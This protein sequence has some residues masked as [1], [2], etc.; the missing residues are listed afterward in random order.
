M[1]IDYTVMIDAVGPGVTAIIT[2][3]L[4]VAVILMA[5][6]LVWSG[7]RYV[8]ALVRGGGDGFRDEVE[9][10]DAMDA[11]ERRKNRGTW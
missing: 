9:Y 6:T 2:L 1:A 3:L 8:L 5:I 11:M 10:W 7:I 4:S